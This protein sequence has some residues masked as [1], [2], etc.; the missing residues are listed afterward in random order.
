MQTFIVMIR[1]VNGLDMKKYM[2]DNLSKNII[3]D[4]RGESLAKW[5]R[6]RE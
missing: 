4:A 2:S 1:K 3:K 6:Y 5:T